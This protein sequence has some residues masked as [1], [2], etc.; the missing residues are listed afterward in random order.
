MR[1]GKPGYFPA[2]SS[3]ELPHPVPLDLW[4]PFGFTKKMTP[5]KKEKS[6]I[7]EINNGAPRTRR[8]E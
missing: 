4:D 2:F 5:E 6:L 7:A 8:H 3:V 1:G